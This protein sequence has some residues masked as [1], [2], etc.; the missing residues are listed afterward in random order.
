MAKISRV[1][2]KTDIGL[3]REKNEDNILV[4]DR[5]GQQ[6]DIK[7]NGQLYVVADG[8]GGHPGGEVASKIACECMIDYY[9]SNT[10]NLK[11]E[12][13]FKARLQHLKSCIYTAH[14]KIIEFGRT[15]K[16]FE[17]MGTTLS[18]LVI[19]DNKALIAHVG[20]SRIYRLR[21]GCLQLLTED[22][23]LAQLCIRMGYLEPEKVANHPI[24]HILS[25]VVGQEIGDIFNSIEN[26]ESGDIFLLCSDGLFSMMC[27]DKIRDTL[28]QYPDIK[29]QC[30]H[31]VGSALENGGK[32]NVT[33][34]VVHV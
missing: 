17:D 31:L 25:Q 10:G 21:R 30:H 19:I 22:H 23:T 12:D 9:S 27:D 33:V 3:K 20:D 18:A 29:D 32:D 5:P 4:I 2:S 28:M 15:D 14:E 16:K 13:Y 24:R 7:R 26:A 11:G 8:M 1:F 6:L 34:I